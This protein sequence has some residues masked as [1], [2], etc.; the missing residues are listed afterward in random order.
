MARILSVIVGV[1]VGG[2]LSGAAPPVA[3]P[4]PADVDA[5]FR[6]IARVLQ[7]PR[8][9][10]CHPAGDAPLQTDRSTPHKQDIRR[11]FE[12]LGGSCGTCHQKSNPSG[13]HDPPGAPHWTMPP[14]STPMV[15]QGKSVAQ[16]CR[17]VKD[18]EKNGHRTL[19]QLLTHVREDAV[20][21]WGWNP[22]GARTLPPLSHDAF[23]RR[24]TDWIQQGAPCPAETPP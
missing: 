20:V 12:E 11:R 17:D 2:L 5:A 1:A 3:P 8:C 9:M 15:F 10:N 13:L 14:E 21:R 6:D 4:A 24:V 18:P 22:G 19:E 16:L 7:S 23:V